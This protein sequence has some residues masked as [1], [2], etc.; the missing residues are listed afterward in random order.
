VAWLSS[1]R[2]AVDSAVQSRDCGHAGRQLTDLNRD[3]IAARP[4]RPFDAQRQRKEESILRERSTIVVP[5]DFSAHSAAALSAAM[6]FGHRLGADLHLIH[7]IQS[8][9]YAFRVQAANAG[10]SLINMLD[11]RESA[12][13][14]LNDAADRAKY[15][16]G[17]IQAHVVE[18]ENIA[19]AIADSAAKLGA[20][21]IAI[22]THGRTGLA[23]VFLGSVAERTLRFAPCPV[24]SVQSPEQSDSEQRH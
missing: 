12:I 11:V 5:Y 19:E 7:V 18:G 15:V 9:D 14:A 6:E 17:K 16:P 10:P 20:D 24:L 3:S 4:S 23:H 21:L 2:N 1:S 22:G 13:E 8:P